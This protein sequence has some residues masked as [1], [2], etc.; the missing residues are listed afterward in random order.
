[1]VTTATPPT[2]TPPTPPPPQQV[3]NEPRRVRVG[4]RVKLVTAFTIAFTIVFSV[5]ATLII[6]FVTNEAERKTVERL[7]DTA[8]GGVIKISAEGLQQILAE[9]PAA[10]PDDPFLANN[11]LYRELN[12][13][14]MNIRTIVPNA[15]PYTYF[16]DSDGQL[17][18]L[19]TWS[20]L[21]PDPNFTVQYRGPVSE[22]VD[23]E[24][25]AV[26]EEGLLR[27]INQEPF[28]DENGQWIANFSPIVTDDG[29]TVAA[30][31]IDFPLAYVA[32][33]RQTALQ[34]VLPILIVSYIA[35][36]ALVFVV[37]TWLTRPLK[38]LT[39]ATAQI[40][41]GKYDVELGTIIDSRFPDELA[42]LA[43]SFDVM[44]DKVRVREQTLTAE[45]TRLKVEIDSKKKEAAV[46]EI[47][48]SDFFAGIAA[49]ANQMR[50]RMKADGDDGG[51]APSLA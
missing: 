4:L 17:R 38:R 27:S 26:M 1:M 32:E 47:L 12:Q 18:W 28:E 16:R 30:I 13:E 33:I 34:V 19:T 37:S 51:I 6:L 42:T 50:S 29:T 20:G 45:V 10:N 25:Y 40:A 48:E 49:K 41:D 8:T 7:E 36:L 44:A 5:L 43:S 39:K 9:V 21:D 31:G 24:T 14:L 11:A 23:A 15:S 3:D 2:A 46:S 22:I 35:L